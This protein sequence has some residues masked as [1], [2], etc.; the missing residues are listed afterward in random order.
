MYSNTHQDAVGIKANNIS[1][2]QN[3]HDTQESAVYILNDIPT[4]T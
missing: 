1:G 2:A 3:I 4:H